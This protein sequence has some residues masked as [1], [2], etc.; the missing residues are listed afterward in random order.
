METLFPIFWKLLSGLLGR[1]LL[2]LE[3]SKK[4]KL[5]ITVR[6]MRKNQFSKGLSTSTK[7]RF[8]S[9]TGTD[10]KIFQGLILKVFPFLLLGFPGFCGRTMSPNLPLLK[11][12]NIAY[13]LP[14]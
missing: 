6:G 4:K 5:K 9:Q 14:C 10:A 2:Y 3:I 11:V 13:L 12:T 1:K 8:Y 7:Y